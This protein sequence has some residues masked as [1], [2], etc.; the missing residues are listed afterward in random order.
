MTAVSGTWSDG[1]GGVLKYCDD[2]PVPPPPP[3]TAYM[4]TLVTF[5]GT[6][7]IPFSVKISSPLAGVCDVSTI[8]TETD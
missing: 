8:V 2:T 7:N 4:F 6:V 1:V 5:A 3:P